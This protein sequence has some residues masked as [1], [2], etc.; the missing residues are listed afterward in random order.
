MMVEGMPAE[1]VE[2]YRDDAGRWRWRALAGNGEEVGRSEQG[3]ARRYY[4]RGRAATL[5]P[6]VRVVVQP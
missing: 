5:N 6:G 3:Y 4:A 1:V 2:V